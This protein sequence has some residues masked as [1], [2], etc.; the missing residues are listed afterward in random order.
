MLMCYHCSPECVLCWPVSS[1]H[2]LHFKYIYYLFFPV[3]VLPTTQFTAGDRKLSTTATRLLFLF[4]GT[5]ILL[6]IFGC[7]SLVVLG[8]FMLYFFITFWKHVMIALS[9]LFLG[10]LSLYPASRHVLQKVFHEKMKFPGK[11]AYSSSVM[12]DI[13]LILMMIIMYIIQSW[14]T[15]MKSPWRNSLMSWRNWRIGSCL[16]TLLEFHMLRWSPFRGMVEQLRSAGGLCFRA[17]SS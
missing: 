15:Q 8:L 13:I 11:T 2:P 7:H 16:E 5:F 9:L 10:C 14:F 6:S 12:I 3:A 1:I 17:G 4:L